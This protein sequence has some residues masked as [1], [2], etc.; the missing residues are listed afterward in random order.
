MS[1]HHLLFRVYRPIIIVF[2]AILLT[3][4][5]VVTTLVVVGTGHIG[6]SMWIVLAGYAAKYWLLVVGIMLVVMQL[7]QFVANGGTRHEFLAGAAVF[8][9]IVTAGFA[10]VVTIGHGVESMVLG[11]GDWRGDGYP[12]LPLDGMLGQFG[13]LFPESLAYLMSGAMIAAGFYRWRPLI[14]LVVM[15]GGA[16]PAAVADGLLGVDEF[17]HVAARLPYPVALAL[18]LAATALVGLALRRAISDV[19]IKRTAG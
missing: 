11:A 2:T 7:R 19:P 15:V 17:G 18:S 9:L 10:A 13:Q 12:T 5:L 8:G 3:S 6:F 16:I 14:G 1:A 4:D